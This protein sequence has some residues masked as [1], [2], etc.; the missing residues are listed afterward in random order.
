MELNKTIVFP[1]YLEQGRNQDF[2]KGGLVN[3]NFCDVILMAY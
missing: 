2:V 3:E 1:D